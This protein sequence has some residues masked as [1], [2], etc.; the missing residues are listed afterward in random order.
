DCP[1]TLTV[2]PVRRNIL[3]PAAN[4]FRP[5]AHKRQKPTTHPPS[6]TPSGTA[7]AVNPQLS[8]A[9]SSHRSGENHTPARSLPSQIPID[10]EVL[11]AFPR[12]RSSEAF[13]R[14]P[15]YRVDRSR[16][17]GIRNPTRKAVVRI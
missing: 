16:R 3:F 6:I 4:P 9:F 11:T 5:T 7:A 17:A 2:A 14:R 13:R 12:V 1:C 10:D 15:H 8:A